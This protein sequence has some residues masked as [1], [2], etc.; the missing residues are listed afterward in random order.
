MTGSVAL[1]LAGCSGSDVGA[2]PTPVAT[3]TAIPSSPTATPSGSATTTGSVTASTPSSKTSQPSLSLEVRTNS[4]LGAEAF[5]RTYFHVLNAAFEGAPVG[6][7]DGYVDNRCE[8]CLNLRSNA[9]RLQSAGL[10]VK[11]APYHVSLFTE[12]PESTA[13]MRTFSA[14]L[15]H[16]KTDVIRSD[17]TVERIDKEER[18]LIEL[19]V[20]RRTNGWLMRD[21][22]QAKMVKP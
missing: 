3:P 17:G 19:A 2:A 7:L 9:E 6:T 13:G 1:A 15:I 4:A 22:A 12:L 18:A 8:S 10:R 5:I 21:M 20:I 11:G 16:R 14:V